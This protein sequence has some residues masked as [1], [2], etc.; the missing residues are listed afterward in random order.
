MQTKK[1]GGGWNYVENGEF[2]SYFGTLA[3]A[4]P[5]AIEKIDARRG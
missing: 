2:S 1:E 5:A 3:D 4:N